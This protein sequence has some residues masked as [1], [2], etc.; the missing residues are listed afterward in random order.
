V[1]ENEHSRLMAELVNETRREVEDAWNWLGLRT[2]VEVVTSDGFSQYI[3]TGVGHSR[4]K[5]LEVIN[6][7]ED[8]YLENM[9][10]AEM[11]KRFLFGDPARGVPQYFAWNGFD[12][13]GNPLVD[14]YP[15]PDGIYSINFNIVLPQNDLTADEHIIRVPGHIV[16]LGAYAKALVERGEDASNGYIVARA[17]Y[18]D[19]LA[20][21][22]SQ[23][24]SLLPGETDWKAV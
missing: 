8:N 22:I 13:A 19:A 1:T 24:S 21:N 11:T 14:L 2:T 6:N 15:I 12:D 17:S 9:T 16:V 3:L 4:F 23:Q 7:T 18:Q 20:S 5:L 10:A